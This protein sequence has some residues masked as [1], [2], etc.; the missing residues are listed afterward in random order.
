MEEGRAMRKDVK[1]E[2]LHIYYLTWLLY[3]TVAA[4]SGTWSGYTELAEIFSVV[5]T[6]DDGLHASL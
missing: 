1:F 2:R 3:Q 6:E 5:H 4:I